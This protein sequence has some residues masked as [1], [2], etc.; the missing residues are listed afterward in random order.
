[1]A[2]PARGAGVRAPAHGMRV[3]RTCTF[4][5]ESGGAVH[6]VMKKEGKKKERNDIVNYDD[7][8]NPYI[9]SNMIML[10]SATMNAKH[11]SKFL[12]I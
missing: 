11:P 5:F 3:Q 6:D 7:T 2:E 1:M 12:K 9:F 4:E 8:E 10:L